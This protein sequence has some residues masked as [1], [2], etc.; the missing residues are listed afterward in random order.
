MLTCF[1]RSLSEDIWNSAAN[2]KLHAI[3]PT[4]GKCVY[5]NQRPQET[6]IIFFVLHIDGTLSFLYYWWSGDAGAPM[7][8]TK[9]FDRD[10]K[11]HYSIHLIRTPT[12]VVDL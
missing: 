1:S 8:R 11:F 12:A 3:Y 2:N 9:F 6:L 10:Y 4:V 5:N 7:Q